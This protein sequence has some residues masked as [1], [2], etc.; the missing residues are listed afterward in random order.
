MTFET[1]QTTT[2]KFDTR[3][4]N[5]VFFFTTNKMIFFG[6]VFDVCVGVCVDE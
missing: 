2:T 4:D 1:F 5:D 6:N 3:D